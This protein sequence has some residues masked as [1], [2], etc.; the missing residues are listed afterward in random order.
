MIGS[1]RYFI[2]FYIISG[3]VGW[4]VVRGVGFE[5]DRYFCDELYSDVDDDVEIGD[6]GKVEF[7]SW[8]W[9]LF[10]KWQNFW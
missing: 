9:S 5:F 1:C 8:R 7:G 4:G 3:S 10:W 2:L 6:G